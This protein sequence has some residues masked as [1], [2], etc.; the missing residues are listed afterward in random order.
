[1]GSHSQYRRRGSAGVL[2]SVTQYNPPSA[3]AWSL[4]YNS[5]DDQTEVVMPVSG[6]PP[7]PNNHLVMRWTLNGGAYQYLP[8]EINDDVEFGP[9][10]L[11][12]TIIAALAWCNASQVE[13]SPYS[14][15]KSVTN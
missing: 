14:A 5:G 9:S 12:G 6:A 2:P 13:A 1:M 11:A 15:T 4:T 3:G 7:A 8:A 10:P